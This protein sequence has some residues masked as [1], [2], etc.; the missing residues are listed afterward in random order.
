MSG[1]SSK[2]VCGASVRR[3]RS[4]PAFALRGFTLIELLVTLTVAGILV[5]IATPAFNSFVQNSRLTTE[6]NTLVYDMSLARSDAVKLDATVEVCAS[7]DHAT[8]SGAWTDGWIVLCT[9]A[10]P[11]GV[12]AAPA[13]LLVA[14]AVRTGNQVDERLA[15]ATSVSFQSTGQTGGPNLQFV[16][17]DGRGVTYAHDVEVNSIGEITS[18]TAPGESVSG[19]ALGGC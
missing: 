15:G 5:A 14:P 3:G 10:C 4:E 1:A 7:S 16:F 12:G 2:Q 6:A 17:C 9:A 11:P 13:L 19:A 8:C 18:S